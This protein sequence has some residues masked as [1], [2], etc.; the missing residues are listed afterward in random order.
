MCRYSCLSQDVEKTY[1]WN[2]ETRERQWGDTKRNTNANLVCLTLNVDLTWCCIVMFS[3]QN[4]SSHISFVDC[5][6][7]RHLICYTG[8]AIYKTIWYSLYFPFDCFNGNSILEMYITLTLS[9]YVHGS[10]F[11]ER[12]MA[13]FGQLEIG[14]P[15]M[16]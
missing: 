14:C 5:V 9:N 12:Y 11:I 15:L 2:N 1:R 7:F 8:H 16:T 13:V 3:N 4:R 10:P 6:S